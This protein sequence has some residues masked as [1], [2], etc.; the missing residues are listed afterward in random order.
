MSA[1]AAVNALLTAA[2]GVTAL[3]STRI[4]PTI[5]PEGTAPPLVVVELV[6]NVR[7]PR[8]DAASASHLATS[9]I[10]LNLVAAD[11]VTIKALREECIAACQFQRGV[12]GGVTVVAIL[13][14]GDGPISYDP[15]TGLY[16]QPADLMVTFHE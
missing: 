13:P 12:I 8:I 3:V 1:E 11:Y 16:H 5:A 4:Y 7:E 10:Q 2:A 9:R 6:S 15:G 14:D